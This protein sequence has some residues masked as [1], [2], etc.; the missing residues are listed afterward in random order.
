M[1]R[2]LVVQ[3]LRLHRLL[4]RFQ[5]ELR[6]PPQRVRELVLCLRDVAG[7][8]GGLEVCDGECMSE[9]VTGLVRKN[10]SQ[11]YLGRP[12]ARRWKDNETCYLH[13][14]LRTVAVKR[15]TAELVVADADELVGW[16]AVLGPAVACFPVVHACF[17]KAELRSEDVGSAEVG[18]MA[19]EM[20][21]STAR[22]QVT[23]DREDGTYCASFAQLAVAVADCRMTRANFSRASLVLPIFH[24]HRARFLLVRVVG[25]TISA[26]GCLWSFSILSCHAYASSCLLR[27]A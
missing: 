26:P 23:D 4:I 10:N 12:R 8:I 13:R 17:V 24:R 18:A 27:H 2:Q 16:R 6:Q 20:K 25:R 15:N 3:L 9:M 14:L 7:G 22:L 21:T 11:L 5:L 1:F 19:R